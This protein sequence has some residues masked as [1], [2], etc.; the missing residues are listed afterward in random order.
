LSCTARY[1]PHINDTGGFY[2]AK[3]IKN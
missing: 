2:V 3:I 1:Y